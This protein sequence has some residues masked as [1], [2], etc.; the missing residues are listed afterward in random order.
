[1]KVTLRTVRTFFRIVIDVAGVSDSGNGTTPGPLVTLIHAGISVQAPGYIL[2]EISK[3]WRSSDAGGFKSDA[4]GAGFLQMLGD[5]VKGDS[6]LKSQF[7]VINEYALA[8]VFA[9]T[10]ATTSTT[11]TTNTSTATT[12]T[13][14]SMPPATG[15]FVF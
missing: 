8:A 10:S 2:S 14:T 15:P 4:V 12:T 11:S 7:T 3:F 13:V 1:M 9:T 6:E 5:A